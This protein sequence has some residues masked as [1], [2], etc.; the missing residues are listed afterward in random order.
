MT[1][2]NDP[3]MAVLPD[4]LAPQL[5]IV[6]CGTAVGA[7]SAQ[8]QAYYAGPGNA[9]WPTLHEVGLTPRRLQPEEYPLLIHH[10]VGLTDLAKAISGADSILGRRHFDR[11]ALENK[12]RHYRPGVLAFTGKRAAQEFLSTAVG[13]GLQRETIGSTALFV[14]P[15]P[16]GAARGFWSITFWHDLAAY[17]THCP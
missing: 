6:F 14:L 4:V 13:Y 1:L 11:S 7:V 15:S 8:R 9:F 2:T 16:S 10:G 12:I 3:D 17:R 5:R